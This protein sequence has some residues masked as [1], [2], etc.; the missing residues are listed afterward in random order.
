MIAPVSAEKS[1]FSILPDETST[2][3][4]H[5][6]CIPDT[7]QFQDTDG[8]ACLVSPVR[9]CSKTSFTRPRTG[10]DGGPEPTARSRPSAGALASAC[11]REFVCVAPQCSLHI[12]ITWVLKKMPDPYP[13][14][15]LKIGVFNAQDV[16]GGGPNVQFGLRT[17]H[18]GS[19]YSKCGPWTSSTSLLWELVRNAESQ[20]P[21]RLMESE[22]TVQQDSPGDF[23]AHWFALWGAKKL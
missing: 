5:R 8:P 1:L 3:F 15:L 16:L 10:V 21:P 12:R 17:S 14:P 22:S 23:C 19:C 18:L 4:P 7:C 20:F 9:H 6:N 13:R 11:G 2:S